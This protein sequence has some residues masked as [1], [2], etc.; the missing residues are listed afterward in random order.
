MARLC[1]SLPEIS[2]A[3]FFRIPIAGKNQKLRASKF[4]GGGDDSTELARHF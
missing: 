2:I 3:L 4:P 1:R